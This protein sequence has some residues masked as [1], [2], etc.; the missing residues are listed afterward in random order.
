MTVYGAGS[1]GRYSNTVA[2]YRT[3][4]GG[5]KTPAGTFTLGEKEAWHSFGSAGYAR[6]AVKYASG[7]YL[8]GPLYFTMDPYD[9]N[10]KY[11]DGS[12][13][14]GG[15]N[16]GGCLRMVVAAIKFIYTNCPSGT[17]LKIVNNSPLGTT[18]PPVPPRNGLSYDPTDPDIVQTTP[19]PSPDPT[20]GPT[21]PPAPDSGSFTTDTPFSP[22]FTAYAKRCIDRVQ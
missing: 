8:H 1:D 9:I 6:Y 13:Y 14:I 2:S 4:H 5:N 21:A 22:A 15:E 19:T 10:P 17:K 7:I 11:Y 18:S 3:S 16:S 20:P 12:H